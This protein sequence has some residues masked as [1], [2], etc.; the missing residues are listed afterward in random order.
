[1]KVKVGS[2]RLSL[3]LPP[4]LFQQRSSQRWAAQQTNSG[5]WVHP[6]GEVW[7]A[8]SADNTVGGVRGVGWVGRAGGVGGVSC[9]GGSSG[10]GGVGGVS[11]VWGGGGRGGGTGGGARGRGE[12]S[13]GAEV[14]RGGEMKW[15]GGGGEVNGGG[16]WS[17]PAGS[18]WG[19][20]SGAAELKWG[21]GVKGE[22]ALTRDLD[23]ELGP[24]GIFYIRPHGERGRT[25]HL[26]EAGGDEEVAEL[27]VRTLLGLK[28]RMVDTA[29]REESS[30]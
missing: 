23:A 1:V 28:M 29:D 2:L 15:G 12:V 7:A 21:G 13:R 5:S 26:E 24:R 4:P 30:S 14:K 25:F 8:Q 16:A 11:G 27:W 10:K 20:G 9:V 6:D 22:V 17:A 19:E 18:G 3:S